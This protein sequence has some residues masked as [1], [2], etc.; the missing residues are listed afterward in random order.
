MFEEKYN[1]IMSE[2]NRIH[3]YINRHMYDISINA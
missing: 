1:K 3:K 2:E